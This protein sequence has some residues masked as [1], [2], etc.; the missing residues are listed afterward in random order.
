MTEEEI[1][2]TS[3]TSSVRTSVGIGFDPFPSC[4]F[5]LFPHAPGV[6]SG[7]RFPH[8]GGVV[9]STAAPPECPLR[10]ERAHSKGWLIKGAF[11]LWILPRPGMPETRQRS[12]AKRLTAEA[13]MTPVYAGAGKNKHGNREGSSEYSGEYSAALTGRPERRDLGFR[14][15]RQLF[16]EVSITG[17]ERLR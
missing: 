16:L 9:A 2:R 1:F 12:D 10:F 3:P 5:C 17:P 14:T 13:L 15:I 8:N 11:H 6:L 4:L 7:T